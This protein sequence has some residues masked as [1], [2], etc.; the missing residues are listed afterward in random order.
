MFPFSSGVQKGSEYNDI[1]KVKQ[2]WSFVLPTPPFACGEQE[3]LPVTKI[4][5]EK[6][7]SG[8]F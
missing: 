4:I 3:D 1:S 2:A 7:S 5:F 6:F 8:T